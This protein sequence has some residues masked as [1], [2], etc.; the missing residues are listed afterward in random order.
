MLCI[1]LFV[2]C[3]NVGHPVFP[4]GTCSDGPELE[5]ILVAIG[6]IENCGNIVVFENFLK[7]FYN[8]FLQFAGGKMMIINTDSQNSIRYAHTAE[9]FRENNWTNKKGNEHSNVYLIQKLSERF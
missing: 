4:G 6:I 3:W 1:F 2:L 8:S 5:A 7:L 9:E